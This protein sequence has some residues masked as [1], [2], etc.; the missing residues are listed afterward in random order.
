MR[1]STCTR[2]LNPSKGE[3]TYYASNGRDLTGWTSIRLSMGI[4]RLPSDFDI[5]FTRPPPGITELLIQPGDRVQVILGPDIVLTGFVDRYQPSYSA[6]EHTIRIAG[7]SLCQELVDCAAFW[8]NGQML[9]LRV[10]QIAKNLCGAYGIDVNLAAG[11]D[12]GDPIPQLNVMAGETSYSILERLCRF[13]GLLM[14][15]QPDGS[16]LIASGGTQDGSSQAAPIGTRVVAGGFAEGVNVLAASAMFSMDG[17]FS[18]YDALYQGLDTLKDIGDGGNL[19]AH[20]SD[21]TVPRF[22]YRVIVSENVTGGAIVAQQRVNWEMARNY[23]R[24][25]QVRLTTDSWR[26][27]DGVLYQPNTLVDIDLPNL[28]LPPVRW[29]ISEVTYKR[30][31]GG[32]TADLVIMPPQAFYQEPLI[33]YPIAPDV[34]NVSNAN[35]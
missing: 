14:Y 32:T 20:A 6:R 35:T 29:L 16:L 23:G 8:P 26:D 33:L 27:T 5:S 18:N 17:R 2:D 1:V 11:T 15:D 30:D 24:S 31:E 22:R 3:P 9:N 34:T 4:E 13:R 25:L 7:R 12:Q 28:T 21:S 19:I 10:L